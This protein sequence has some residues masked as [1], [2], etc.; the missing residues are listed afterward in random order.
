MASQ[1]LEDSAGPFPLGHL[2]LPHSSDRLGHELSKNR[3]LFSMW[4]PLGAR[5]SVCTQ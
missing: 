5:R 3:K 4:V 2:T 1:A